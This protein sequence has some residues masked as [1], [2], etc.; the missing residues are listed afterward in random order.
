[1]QHA[2]LF[3]L[4]DEVPLLA[5]LDGMAPMLRALPKA[6]WKRHHA[7]WQ[8]ARKFTRESIYPRS[9]SHE[10]AMHDDPRWVDEDFLVAAGRAGLFSTAC[11]R[12]LGG[13]GLGG[14]AAGL[15]LEEL[16]AGCA[17]LGNI[18][19]AHNLG[20]IGLLFARNLELSRRIQ[21]EV[22]RGADNGKPVVL[23]CAVTEPTAGSDVE[24]IESMK[25][26]RIG[27]VAEDVPGGYRLSGTKVFISNGTFARYVLAAAAFDR[28]R[29]RETWTMFLVDTTSP[30]FSV[31]RVESKMGMKANPAA[32]LYLDNVFVPTNFMVSDRIGD[33]MEATEVVLGASRGPVGAIATGIARG[34]LERFLLF[35]NQKRHRGRPLCEYAF[36]QDII[37]ESL[38]EI[39]ACRS[40]WLN[41]T[42]SFDRT[43]VGA[44]ANTLAPEL[45][46]LPGAAA[47]TRHLSRSPSRRRWL[48]DQFDARYA[49]PSENVLTHASLAKRKCSEAALSIV[50]R[51]MGL[52]GPAALD[53]T[54]EMEKIWRDAKLTQIYEGTNQVNRLCIYER[55]IAP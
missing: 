17:G 55:G 43:G 7:V 11:F 38:E 35:A 40:T 21:L 48:A 16:C 23:A 10:R 3:D 2:K 19:G 53:P 44:L 15:A 14:T 18:I 6:E 54:W 49:K 46:R 33:G 50:S 47:V 5:D 27:T 41:A 31:T 34:A 9:L 25:T 20:L 4:I 36:V 13:D 1:M 39:G 42:L 8:R 12:S 26:A 30:G 51:L 37:T 45:Y 52:M 32:E 22:T 24:E 29:P 28:Q